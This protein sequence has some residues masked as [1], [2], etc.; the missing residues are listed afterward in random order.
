MADAT[1]ALE[2]YIDP[3]G[4]QFE[5][6]FLDNG[7]TTLGVHFSAFF[8]AWGDSKPYRDS[9]QGYFHRLKMLGSCID[10]DWLFLCDPY[11][12]ERNGTYYL[13]E[14]G[15]FFVERA[16][17]QIITS[18]LA[19]PRHAPARTTTVGSSMGATAAI[20]FALLHDLCGVV[21]V[22]PHIDLDISAVLQGREQ[23]VAFTLADGLTQA[24]HNYDTTR[25][26]R[27]LLAE[28]AADLALPRLFVQSC[29]DDAGVH[30]EQVEPLL[31]NW[32]GR[33][34]EAWLDE[35][36]LGGHTSDWATRPLLLDAMAALLAHAEPDVEAYQRDAR[37]A[38]TRVTPPI[39]HRARGAVSR[40]LKSQGLRR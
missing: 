18:T 34:G 23:H 28:R 33:G 15:D 24:V 38:G 37:F 40:W 21:A 13:G 26:I 8:G 35:R 39:S 36:P 2:R 14:K 10:H 30:Q 17:S 5:Y 1:L 16:M 31:A 19:S 6:A 12:A 11:G 7:R 20:K 22:S 3:E 4:R 27:R 32:R 9:F 25:R 29:A